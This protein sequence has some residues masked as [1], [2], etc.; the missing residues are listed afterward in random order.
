MDNEIFPWNPSQV[1]NFSPSPRPQS[2]KPTSKAKKLFERGK[3]VLPYFGVALFLLVLFLATRKNSDPPSSYHP[4]ESID[5]FTPLFPLS[6]GEELSPDALRLVPVKKSLF[7]KTQLLALMN[8][9]NLSE[10]KGRLVAKKA[11]FPGK[12]LFW[13]DL[14]LKKRAT[15]RPGVKILY[16]GAQ[17]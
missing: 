15:V 16:S 10:L 14:D 5:V 8:P 2:E 3:E 17:P 11:L 6:K 9:E 7:S 12:A 13:T 4:P 1:G